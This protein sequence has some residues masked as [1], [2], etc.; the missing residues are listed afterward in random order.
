MTPSDH[1]SPAG[2]YERKVMTSG[3]TAMIEDGAPRRSS[4]QLKLGC[5]HCTQ[6]SRAGSKRRPG[7]RG[8]IAPWRGQSRR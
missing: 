6:A 2:V 1:T 3:D 5:A 7:P 8:A 4:S